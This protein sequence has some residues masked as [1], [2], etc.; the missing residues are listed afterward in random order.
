MKSEYI[1]PFDFPIKLLKLSGTWQR[2]SSSW[3]YFFY[4]AT[5]HFI[6]I[7]LYTLMMFFYLFDYET[8]DDFAAFIALLPTYLSL[9]VK[10]HIIM[11]RVEDIEEM[12]S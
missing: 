6:F 11:Y 8:F 4:G 5:M 9:T 7:D 12:K 2:K 1:F 10:S 3:I